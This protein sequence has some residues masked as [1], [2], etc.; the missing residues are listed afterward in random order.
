MKRAAL[1][2]LLLLAG[3]MEEE[4]PYGAV[5]NLE[6]PAFGENPG[7]RLAVKDDEI[8][9]TLSDPG[10]GPRSFSYTGVTAS[11]RGKVT[12]WEGRGGMPITVEAG[13]GP[14]RAGGRAFEDLVTVSLSGR[15]L[16]GCGGAE[17]P[18]MRG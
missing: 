15:Q 17:R 16:H 8:V 7:W 6:Y 5:H 18:G 11:V 12:R 10:A 14:C 2:P 3:C 9:L 4:R 1:F 13:P